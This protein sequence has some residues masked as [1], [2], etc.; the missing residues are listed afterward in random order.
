VSMLFFRV[1]T[2]HQLVGRYHRFGETHCLHL[3]PRRPTSTSVNIFVAC[4]NVYRLCYTVTCNLLHVIY[5]N[6]LLFMITGLFTSTIP[7]IASI[8][9]DYG[10]DDWGSIPDRGRGFFLLAS[11]SRPALGPS[12]PPVQWVP[13]VL[14]PGVKRGR[15]V[16]LTTHPHLVP[17]LGMRAIPPPPISSSMACSG[18]ALLLQYHIYT[19]VGVYIQFQY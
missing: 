7:Y 6:Q 8:V 18:T 13:G 3:Q 19:Y 16:M 11:A 2:P 1:I 4:R 12:Q 5:N 17:R 10:L 15:G 9:A 14:S